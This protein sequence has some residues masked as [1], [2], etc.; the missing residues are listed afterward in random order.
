MRRLRGALPAA[1]VCLLVG[2]QSGAD[3]ERI[4]EKPTATS[5]PLPN[6]LWIV[7]EDHSPDLGSYGDSYAITPNLDRL[8]TEG[9][10]F[11][12][13]FAS[14]PA[15]GPARSTLI[16]GMYATTLG[17]H[18]MRST[19]VPPA[20]V[21]AFPE[22]LRAAGY[23]TSNNAKTDYNFSP[24]LATEPNRAVSEAPLGLWDD[25]S[26]EA[27]WRNREPDQSFF[28]V[29]NLGVTHE[30]QVRLPDDQ[31]AERTRSLTADQRHDPV[32]ATL[33]PYYPDTAVVREN[34]ARYYDLVTVMDGQ[35]GE[36][37][38][39]LEADGLADDTIVFFF[40]DHGRGLSRAKRWVYDS[41]L[42]VPLIVRWPGRIE[43]GSVRKDLVS[44]LDFAPTL[45][46]LARAPVADHMHGRVFLG[47]GTEP[48]PAQLFFTRDRMDKA[49]DRIRGVRDERY[50][51]IRNF[52]PGLPYA[53]PI[54]FMDEMPMMQ[55]WRRLAAE[56]ALTGPPAQFFA[57]TKPAEELYDTESDPHEVVNLADDP[58]YAGQLAVMRGALESWIVETG[59][60]GEV[61]EAELVSQF[62]P[63]GV[64]PTTEPPKV[65]PQGGTYHGPPQVTI[66]CPDDGSTAVFTTD[67]G[68]DPRWRLYMWPFWM[69][70]P[71]LRAQCGR[72]GYFDSDIVSY[73]FDVEM[74]W[75]IPEG[76]SPRRLPG[77]IQTWR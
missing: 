44:F 51:Y 52:E 55:E 50:K 23:Y 74:H 61:P 12:R 76:T 4:V 8:A 69:G 57:K 65:Q 70:D 60:L 68:D 66:T 72:L 75:V 20:Y 64:P 36:I 6:I 2:C 43:A 3:P 28:S 29:I 32:S 48:P 56:G 59:D 63:D 27:H 19:A 26:R 31:F 34:W 71:R 11:T 38:A 1:M 35:V 5:S 67:P 25:S 15:G 10:R 39:E 58:A 49:Y 41:G 45:L 73:D 14:S 7:A 13:A 53:Q 24:W 17:S 30:G 22:W 62:R 21:R 54:A 37:L 46:S 42:Q 40:G 77:Q 47:E 18:H 9:T 16:T 33:P